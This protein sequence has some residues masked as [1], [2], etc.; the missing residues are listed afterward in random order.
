MNS[1]AL[2]KS[3]RELLGHWSSVEPLWRDARGAQFR[4]RFIEPLPDMVRNAENLME[5]LHSLLNKI[6]HDCE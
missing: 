4:D 1:S 3:I 6:R 2:S 5:E